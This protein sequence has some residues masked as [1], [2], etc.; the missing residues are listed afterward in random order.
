VIAAALLALTTGSSVLIILATL[1]TRIVRTSPR[2]RAHRAWRR[3]ENVVEFTA[4]RWTSHPG[5]LIARFGD[6]FND[7]AILSCP[8]VPSGRKI[9]RKIKWSSAPVPCRPFRTRLGTRPP[10]W[11]HPLRAEIHEIELGPKENRLPA[12]YIPGKS[13]HWTIHVQGIRTARE[14]TF[15]SMEATVGAGN[16]TVSVT[17]RGCGEI[18]TT[19][20]SSLGQEEWRDLEPAIGF[21]REHGARR[22]SII[23]WSLGASIALELSRERPGLI[24]DLILVS[25]V[26]DWLD[27][28]EYGVRRTGLPR[29]VG[30]AVGRF[31]GTRLS[32]RMLRGSA[33]VDV[34]R[35]RW[36]N[37]GDLKVPT[38]VMHS[39]GDE[40]VPFEQSAR[41][42]QAHRELVELVELPAAPHAW[43]TATAEPIFRSALVTALKAHHKS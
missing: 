36:S 7:Y 13:S 38:T 40:M 1:G 20:A 27:T 23:G 31:L 42:C 14:V 29:A 5:E 15:P 17:F 22:V 28:I 26:T 8:E 25:P 30:T 19:R 16:P 12:W 35:L 34:T 11:A 32:S 24:D 21:A 33:P 2:R 6:G 39:R 18:M 3:R 4:N 37:P 41:F 43:L 9:L 10:L